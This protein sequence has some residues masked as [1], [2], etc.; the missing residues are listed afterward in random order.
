MSRSFVLGVVLAIASSSGFAQGAMVET[1]AV[2]STYI[3]DAVPVVSS[4]LIV[5]INGVPVVP[6]QPPAIV[7]NVLQGELALPPGT[8]G[9][10]FKIADGFGGFGLPSV[11]SWTPAVSAVPSAPDG[12]FLFGTFGITNGIFFFQASFEM[13]F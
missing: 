4:T 3:G 13:T 8:T 6:T 10:E 9:V 1:D 5:H 2:F 11:L 12:S 7:N